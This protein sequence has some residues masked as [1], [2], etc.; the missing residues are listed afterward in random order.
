MI[1]QTVK[2]AFTSYFRF[3]NERTLSTDL[4][5][6]LSII[7][8][9]NVT[10]YVDK[11]RRY[12]NQIVIHD[13]CK[14]DKL[15]QILNLYSSEFSPEISLEPKAQ[16]AEIHSF[17][18]SKG[19]H[20]E[21]LHEFLYLLPK[22]GQSLPSHS[23]TINIERW[24][25]DQVNDFLTLLKTSGLQCTAEV[26]QEKRHLYCTDTFRC[27]VASVDGVPCAWAT[28]FIDGEV[29]T[30]ANAYTQEAF[31][32]KGCQ[33]ALLH[34]RIE[35]AVE[36]GASLLLTDVMPDSVSSRN[37]QTVGFVT[38]CVKEV[39]CIEESLFL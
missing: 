8:S 10:A 18:Q 3:N 7:E 16:N 33:T 6:E 37:C 13:V 30:L 12:D 23:N 31:R 26:W 9:D 2:D 25:G 21:F 36:Q 5:S 27:F 38:D 32:G 1:P 39:W 19:F 34:A 28:T 20:Q 17:L 24:E 15:E 29:A 22:S 11:T 14:I 35:D 4:P